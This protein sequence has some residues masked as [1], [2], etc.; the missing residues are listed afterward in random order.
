MSA[1]AIRRGVGD[2]DGEWH[3]VVSV[4]LSLERIVSGGDEGGVIS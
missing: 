4:Q 3:A 1:P 2:T